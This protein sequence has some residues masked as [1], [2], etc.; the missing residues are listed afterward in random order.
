M[1]YKHGTIAIGYQTTR[2]NATHLPSPQPS[3]AGLG[4]FHVRIY[5]KLC[6]AGNFLPLHVAK[7]Q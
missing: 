5:R 4:P 6:Q 3:N 2:L 7:Q 1:E